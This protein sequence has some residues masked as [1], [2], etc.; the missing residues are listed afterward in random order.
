MPYVAAAATY[1]ADV[2]E[3]ALGFA[4]VVGLIGWLAGSSWRRYVRARS[5]YEKSVEGRRKAKEARGSALWPA[6]MWIV[7]LALVLYAALAALA[8]RTA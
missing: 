7:I 5:D 1:H 2:G 3:F 4:L 6:L 8:N